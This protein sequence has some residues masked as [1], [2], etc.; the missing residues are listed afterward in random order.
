MPATT[1]PHVHAPQTPPMHRTIHTPVDMMTSRPIIVASP[2]SMHMPASKAQ[3]YMQPASNN[4]SGMFGGMY[5]GHPFV[6]ATSPTNIDV[7]AGHVAS[8]THPLTPNM[9]GLHLLTSSGITE[10]G[11]DYA[12]DERVRFP[13]AALCARV[14]V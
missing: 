11:A 5:R 1:M 13:P 2:A 9:G 14:C 7:F 3:T 10:G 12:N 4:S 6:D 8:P